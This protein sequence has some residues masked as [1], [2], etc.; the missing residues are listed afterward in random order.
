MRTK[1]ASARGPTPA[2]LRNTP[3][4]ESAILGYLALRSASAQSPHK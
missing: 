4:S 3:S 2:S 1:S